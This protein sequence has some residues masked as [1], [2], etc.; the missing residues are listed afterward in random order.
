MIRLTHPRS[1]ARAPLNRSRDEERLPRDARP[2]STSGLRYDLRSL[3]AGGEG[4]LR[5]A[6]LGGHRLPHWNL[7]PSR[8]VLDKVPDRGSRIGL[9]DRVRRL[10]P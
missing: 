1:C 9:G 7:A 6:S 3:T 10:V 8:A 5:F 2:A 4:H